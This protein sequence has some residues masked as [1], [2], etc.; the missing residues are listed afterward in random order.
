MQSSNANK[1]DRGTRPSLSQTIDD[2]CRGATIHR[3]EAYVEDRLQ[4]IVPVAV[5]LGQRNDAVQQVRIGFQL[6]EV[7]LVK[8]PQQRRSSRR[9]HQVVTRPTREPNTCKGAALEVPIGP[10]IMS[11]CFHEPRLWL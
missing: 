8:I 3:D 6:I 10:E 5:A 4:Q 1:E 2:G 7:G 9:A 11:I